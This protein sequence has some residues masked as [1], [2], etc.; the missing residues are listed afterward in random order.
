MIETKVETVAP[1][2]EQDF[3]STMADFGWTLQSSR[4]E[5]PVKLTF[6]RDTAMP[7][8]ERIAELEK[9]YFSIA[10]SRPEELPPFSFEVWLVLFF[11]VF[12]LAFLMTFL[13]IRAKK[14]WDEA[15]CDWFLMMEE[16]AEPKRK[17]AAALVR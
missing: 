9:G 7:N 12:P 4:G 1:S 14:K 11:V 8:Y 10:N 3:I 13:R 6:Q 15:F 5:F 17:E 2:E 16:E